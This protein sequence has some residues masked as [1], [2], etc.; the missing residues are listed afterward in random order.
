MVGPDMNYWILNQQFIDTFLF[1][2]LANIPV[3]GGWGGGG[4]GF[5]KRVVAVVP[6][7]AA[8]TAHPPEYVHCNKST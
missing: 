4:E 8:L 2:S 3:D 5:W 6:I 1:A 7:E